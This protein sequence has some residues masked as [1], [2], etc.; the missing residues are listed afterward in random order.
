MQISS[1]RN[2]SNRNSLASPLKFP[3]LEWAHLT[4]LYPLI[5]T[6]QSSILSY[7]FRHTN[8]NHLEIPS[9][10]QQTKTNKKKETKPFHRRDVNNNSPKKG[11]PRDNFRHTNSKSMVGKK[12]KKTKLKKQKKE[13]ISGC[14]NGSVERIKGVALQ[15]IGSG[16]RSIIYTRVNRARVHH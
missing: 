16:P 13:L 9:F 5:K 12:K 2:S 6:L 14:W 3:N 1:L 8:F 15:C 4:S 11:E 7:Y 10:F